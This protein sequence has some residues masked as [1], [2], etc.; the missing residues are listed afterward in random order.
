MRGPSSRAT[1]LRAGAV[2]VSSWRP[3]W[4]V[5]APTRR[6]GCA[7]GAPGRC[8]VGRAQP[9]SVTCGRRGPWLA[10]VSV[11]HEASSWRT[12]HRTG[13]CWA[14]SCVAWIATCP[15]VPA[16]H[17]CTPD[18]DTRRGCRSLLPPGEGRRGSRA[19]LD[20][21]PG[22]GARRGLHASRDQAAPADDRVRR[23]FYLGP[24]ACGRRVGRRACIAP[25][26]AGPGG[27]V[28]A[29]AEAESSCC[30]FFTFG[31]STHEQ[32]ASGV[33]LTLHV[34]VPPRHVDVLGGLATRALLASRPT[35]ENQA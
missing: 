27:T 17:S 19:A 1:D 31:V 4:W 32:S 15:E 13:R 30:S 34:T 8:T 23:P 10:E 33:T 12:A 9:R 16:S 2:R 35:T 20:G 29:L 22:L 7:S 11:G 28:R 26:R 25:C 18:D 21:G 14:L 5:W 24:E 3:S 6:Q